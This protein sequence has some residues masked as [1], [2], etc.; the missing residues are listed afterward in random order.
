MQSTAHHKR[1]A[2]RS[3]TKVKKTRRNE[4]IFGLNGRF[5]YFKD[6]RN[7]KGNHSTFCKYCQHLSKVIGKVS[8]LLLIAFIS[9]HFLL[10]NKSH[11]TWVI[12]WKFDNQNLFQTSTN[13]NKV[14]RSRR[15]AF[16]MAQAGDDA[17]EKSENNDSLA[18]QIAKRLTKKTRHF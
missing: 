18:M 3:L 2:H 7:I 4:D 13:L 11:R 12:F 15:S 16:W 6:T 9:R 10:N 1:N 14:W 17:N 8:P 5:K